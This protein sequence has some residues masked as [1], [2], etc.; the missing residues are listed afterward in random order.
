MDFLLRVLLANGS[1]RNGYY[2]AALRGYDVLGFIRETI[3]KSNSTTSLG[4]ETD[5][6]V[7]ELKI[8]VENGSYS[9]DSSG[10]TIVAN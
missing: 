8:E 4:H 10:R 5:R 3:H 1:Q 7:N 9:E 6:D 2:S